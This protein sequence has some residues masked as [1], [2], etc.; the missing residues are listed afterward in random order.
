[1]AEMVEKYIRI[2][3]K[4]KVAKP[5]R[6]H[7]RVG[8]FIVFGHLFV[9]ERGWCK[10]GLERA[11]W[12]YLAQIRQKPD[13]PYTPLVFDIATAAE[14]AALDAQD[15][16]AAKNKLVVEQEAVDLTTRDLQNEPGHVMTAAERA[17]EARIAKADGSYEADSPVSQKRKPGRPRKV[18][19]TADDAKQRL[20]KLR[21]QAL[22]KL[23][24]HFR[25]EEKRKAEARW[26][27]ME[28]IGP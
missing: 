21:V 15:A 14:R 27:K 3:P 8:R 2:R 18:T 25:D 19:A 28:K 9:E 12:A 23:H 11:Q 22:M 17:R 20:Q 6:I 1:M 16:Q 13:D 24:K 7:N 4:S 5:D 10:L 26:A